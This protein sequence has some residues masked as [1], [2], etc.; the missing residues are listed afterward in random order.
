MANITLSTPQIS[1]NGEI[2]RI[3]PNT[4]KIVGGFGSVNVR[5]ASGGGGDSVSVHSR[6][7]EDF[8][9][10]WSF[11]VYPE[12]DI[13]KLIP[14]WS[15]ATS[16]VNLSAINSDALGNPIATYSTEQASLVVDPEIAFASD[17]VIMLE[18]SGNKII[19]G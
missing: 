1:I 15:S 5:S 4:L 2:I 7:A 11:D 18:F 13:I 8:I 3:A 12:A 10:K 14:E 16:G 6:N 17:G 9:S 19:I